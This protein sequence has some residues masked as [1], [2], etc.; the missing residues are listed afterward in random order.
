MYYFGGRHILLQSSMADFIPCDLLLQK[1][2]W[3]AFIKYT[4]RN[5][6]GDERGEGVETKKIVFRLTPP[7][8]LL[9]LICSG[10][11]T[12]WSPIPSVINTSEEQNWM[13]AVR[14]L[15]ILAIFQSKVM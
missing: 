11:R 6:F 9:S 4:F 15:Q 12:E 5:N 2:Y 1:A 8:P 14:L 13:S 3:A 7:P 10:N